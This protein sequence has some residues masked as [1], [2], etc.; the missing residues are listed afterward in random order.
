MSTT[1]QTPQVEKVVVDLASPELASSGPLTR[2]WIGV[3]RECPFWSI[4]AGGVSFP[5]FTG[6]VNFDERGEPDRPLSFGKQID[7]D[8]RQ[9]ADIKAAIARRVVR[10][11]SPP[12]EPGL[13]GERPRYT[14][15][16][17][18]RIL[19]IDSELVRVQRGDV[20]LAK[21]TYMTKLSE[22]SAEDLRTEGFVPETML[23][24]EPEKEKAQ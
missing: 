11:T 3:T 1:K 22:V 19:P 20:P 13:V 12:R 18:A 9:V 23:T 5:L 21:F 24:V 7:L 6:F 4:T 8:A 15:R 10:Y 14:R 2:Y 16:R 17:R